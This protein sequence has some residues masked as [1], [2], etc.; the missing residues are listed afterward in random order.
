MSNARNQAGDRKA[1]TLETLPLS[2]LFPPGPTSGIAFTAMIDRDYALTGAAL[3]TP[4]NRTRPGASSAVVSLSKHTATLSPHQA[5]ANR[6]IKSP[7]VRSLVRKNKPRSS[8][9]N[10]LVVDDV[11]DV[12]EMIALFLKHAGYHVATA[13]SALT[14]LQLAEERNFDLIISD[15][16]MPRMNGYELAGELRRRSEYQSTP[17]IAVTGYSEYDDRGRALQA[18]FS[19]HLTKPIDPSQLLDLMHELLG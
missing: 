12:T 15:I 4:V 9:K 1:T 19:A 14:A 10:V 7:K 8:P 5:F 6:A 11:P 17:I 18:G 3:P 2:F 16:G 13:D